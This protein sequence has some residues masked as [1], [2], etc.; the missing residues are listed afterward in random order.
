MRREE[1]EP[2]GDES[3]FTA[4]RKWLQR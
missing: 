3:V 1:L 2:D 4:V